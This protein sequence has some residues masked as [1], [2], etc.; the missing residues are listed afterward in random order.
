[1]L[2]N[3]ATAYDSS[4]ANFQ[5]Y[6]GGEF[7]KTEDGLSALDAQRNATNEVVMSQLMGRLSPGTRQLLGRRALATGATS[8]GSGAVQDGYTY[9]LGLTAE[10]QVQRGISNYGSLYEQY[11]RFVP[12]ISPLDML[13]YGGLTSNAALQK[14]SPTRPATGIPSWPRR[15]RC[16]EDSTRNPRQSA[17][18]SGPAPRLR[19]RA[20]PPM[21]WVRQ[22]WRCSWAVPPPR[23]W[24][25][26]RAG[27]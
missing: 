26:A 6:L 4:A 18:S 19:M 14:L 7:G 27:R 21:R 5:R 10:D 9:Q 24:A 23:L 22:K 20:K 12:Q 25:P 17:G 8:L 13:N 3:T 11:G 2:A 1:M 15:E 16:S